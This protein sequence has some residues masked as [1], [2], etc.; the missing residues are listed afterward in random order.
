MAARKS[1]VTLRPSATEVGRRTSH[2]R[3]RLGMSKVVFARKLGISRNTLTHYERGG[4]IPR[5]TTLARIAQAGGVSVDWL[6]NGR[7]AEGT[8]AD[9]EWEHAFQ[10]LRFVWR[11]PRRRPIVLAVLGALTRNGVQHHAR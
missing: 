3:E 6:L 2:V 7:A 10:Q 8:R 5:S 4:G 1:S 9:P 11:D